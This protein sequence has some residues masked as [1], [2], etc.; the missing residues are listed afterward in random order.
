MISVRA[1]YEHHFV[2]LIQK[3]SGPARSFQRFRNA[4]DF[5]NHDN[6]VTYI[7]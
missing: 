3:D 2:A 1:Q 4:R 6:I 5:H 7:L